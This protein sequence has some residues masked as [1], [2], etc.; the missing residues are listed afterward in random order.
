MSEEMGTERLIM[1]R[2]RIILYGL[3]I[4]MKENS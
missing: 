4:Y 2:S 3:F 1:I